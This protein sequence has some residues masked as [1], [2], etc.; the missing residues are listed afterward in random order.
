MDFLRAKLRT[1]VIHAR[2]VPYVIIIALTFV[3]DAFER[4]ASLLVVLAQD[5]GGRLVYLEMSPVVPEM[6]W[7]VSWEGVAAGVLVFLIWVGLD[8]Y[9]PKM[10]F[11]FKVGKPWNPFKEFGDGSAMGIFFV[12]VRT[13]GSAVVVPP[14]EEAFFVLSSIVTSFGPVHSNAVQPSALAFPGGDFSRCLPWYTSGMAGWF[15]LRT[16]LPGARHPKESPRGRHARPW[17]HQFSPWSLYP[18]ERRL[19]VL[20]ITQHVDALWSTCDP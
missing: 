6:K 11:L 9:Y 19:A 14:I 2:V 16:V 20:V 12:A 7:A 5:A 1:S 17:N 3:Q 8:P 15:P 18:L 4:P 13:I 10:E